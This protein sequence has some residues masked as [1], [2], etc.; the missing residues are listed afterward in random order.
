MSEKE[1][2]IKSRTESIPFSQGKMKLEDYLAT[3]PES[4]C[5]LVDGNYLHHSPASYK[6]NRLRG[7]LE[8]VIRFFVEKHHLGEVIS[9]NFPVKLNENNWREPDLAI[10]IKERLKDLKETVFIGIPAFILEIISEDSRYRDEVRKR[11]EY[12]SLGVDEYWI[13]DP[14]SFERSVFLRRVGGRFEPVQFLTDRI[15]S[16]TIKG[17]F[18]KKDWIWS[19]TG[20]PPLDTV[21]KELNLIKK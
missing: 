16:V 14:D 1:G 21:F 9:E 19:R 6:H 11:A 10:I 18:F 17:L 12:E 4:K 13:I 5:D 8:S 3:A 7:F 15:E 2:T 20:F